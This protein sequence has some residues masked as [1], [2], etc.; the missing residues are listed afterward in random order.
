MLHLRC[1]A[2][3]A[4]DARALRHRLQVSMLHIGLQQQ[5]DAVRQGISEVFSLAKLDRLSGFN[6]I[7]AIGANPL[8]EDEEW[9]QMIKMMILSPDSPDLAKS[10]LKLVQ[11]ALRLVK[12]SAIGNHVVLFGSSNV[13]VQAFRREFCKAIFGVPQV[14]SS[15]AIKFTTK[16][17]R[18][19]K[20]CHFDNCHSILELQESQ[21]RLNFQT[22]AVSAAAQTHQIKILGAARLQLQFEPHLASSSFKGNRAARVSPKSFEIESCVYS[23]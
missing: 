10:Y 9:E 3:V 18:P 19:G 16:L 8:I 21:S 2:P 1:F 6:L 17:R 20:P 15:K 12:N 7:D 11:A 23:C 4:V 5:V 22:S 13:D 14:D